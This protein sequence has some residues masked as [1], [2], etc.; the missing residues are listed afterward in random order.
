[1]LFSHYYITTIFTILIYLFNHSFLL[2]FQTL[3]LPLQFINLFST[4]SQQMIFLFNLLFY[5]I[6]K[7]C[8]LYQ[9]FHLLNFLFYFLILRLINFL[10][11]FYHSSLYNH[12]TTI[13]FFLTI[14]ILVYFL[15]LKSI[16]L[17]NYYINNNFY[18]C[19]IRFQKLKSIYLNYL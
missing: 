13:Y 10:I 8:L 9:Y 16:P 7:S 18:N 12:H 5:Y 3:K 6:F 14:I 11:L 19:F 4:F 1:M 2:N 17:K 15:Y